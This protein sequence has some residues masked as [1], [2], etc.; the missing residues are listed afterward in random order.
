MRQ[1]IVRAACASLL[2]PLSLVASVAHGAAEPVRRTITH[3]DV[4]LMQRP[5]ALAASPDGRW[6]VASVAEPSYEE[7]K[8]RSDLWLMPADGSSGSPRRLTSSKSSEGDPVWSPDSTRI[9]FS[10]KREDDEAEQIYVLD[11]GG[12]EAQRV[13]NWP[14]GAKAPR[15]SPDGRAIL[16]AGPTHP[17]ALTLEDN[18]KA[19]ADRKARK[20]NARAYDSFPIRHWDRW[21]DELRPSLI[22]QPLDGNS[23]RPRPA[24]GQRAAQ[25]AG[26]RRPARQRR[27]HPRCR[28]DARRQ[29]RR[30][31]RHHQPA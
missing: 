9:A 10:A 25:G 13:T 20:Y 3:E 24:R 18:V 17:G 29:R 4:W 22:V 16:F 1:F 11:L 30:V 26:I 19:A 5:G 28:M 7:D 21:L 8:R 6:F 14:G 2:L 31:R 12:G 15:F 23:T 27:R